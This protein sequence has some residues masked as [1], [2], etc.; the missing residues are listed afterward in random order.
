[1]D[2]YTIQHITKSVANVEEPVI[3]KETKTTRRVF[4]A[5]IN[6]AKIDKGETVSGTILHQRKGLKND[7]ED[8]D[9]IELKKLKAGEGVKICQGWV[10]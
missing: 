7:W 9:S 10:R 8:I 5:Q 2:D 4:L 1:M 6:D 3:I